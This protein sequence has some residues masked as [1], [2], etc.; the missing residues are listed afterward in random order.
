MSE[1][2]THYR[3][4]PTAPNPFGEAEPA[5][6]GDLDAVLDRGRM[7]RST[8]LDPIIEYRTPGGPWRTYH[9]VVT[10]EALSR[11]GLARIIVDKKLNPNT[12]KM[13]TST[14]WDITAEGQR[15][16]MLAATADPL[17]FNIED[18]RPEK[19]Q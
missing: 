5:F 18:Y 14:V 2:V 8:G 10:L 6:E 7:H 16:I 13:M 1:N 3:S 12:G 15:V 4:R 11:I 17:A 9:P 19:P